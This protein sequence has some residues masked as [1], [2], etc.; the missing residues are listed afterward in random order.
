MQNKGLRF[1]WLAL[2]AWR[3]SR[4]NRSRLFLFI[5]SIIIG[6]AALVAIYSLSDNLKKEID[7]QA[8][9]LLGADLEISSR[10]SYS[11]ALLKIIDSLG[12]QRSEERRFSSMIFFTK[13]NGTRIIEVRALGGGFPYYG[14]LS[15]VPAAAGRSFRKG[16]Q[17]LVDQTLMLQFGAQVGDSV[18]IGNTV[19]AIAG[20]L[21][22]A[23][24]QTGVSASVAPVVYIPLETLAQTGLEQK[25]SRINYRYYVKWNKPVDMQAV[26][27]RIEEPFELEGINWDTV[28]SQKEDTARSF[29]DVTRF[30]SLVAFIALLLGCI[31]VASAIQIYIREKISTIAILRCLGTTARQAFLIYLIQIIAIGFI[32]SLIGAVLGTVVQQ[33]LPVVLKDL[34]PVEV[35]TG[36]S[37][38]SVIQG[39]VLGVMISILFALLSLVSIRKISPLNTLRLSFQHH[40]LVKDPVKWLVYVLLAFFI[41]G[42]TYLQLEGWRQALVFT[43]GLL[44]AFFVLSAIAALLMWAV[45]KFFPF[46]WSFL[47]RQGVANLYR[48]NNQTRILIVSIGLGTALIC[49]LFFIQTILLNRVVLTASGEQPNMVLFDIQSAQR[50]PLLT[51]ARKNGLPAEGTVP[52]VT[53]RLEAVNQVTPAVLRKDS[54]LRM[55]RWVF[56]REYRV[57]FRD[58]LIASEKLTRGKWTG[59]A[60]ESGP[61]YVSVEEGFAE[62]NGIDIGDTLHFNVQGV[63]MPTIVGSYR[64]VDWNRMQTNFLVVFPKG[65]L[66]EAPQFHV[67]LTRVPSTE[68]SARFQQAVVRQFPNIS[69]I[70]LGLVLNILNAIMDKVGFVIRF[71]AAFSIITGL[72]VLIASVLISKYQRMQ[73]NVLLRTLG[74]KSR[75]VFV[76]TALEYFILGA[77]AAATGIL[78]ALGGSWALA[79]FLFETTFT[80]QVLPVVIVFFAV[81][82][83]TV[84]IGLFNSRSALSR[85]PLEVLRQ[86]V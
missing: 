58:S 62:R 82:L 26:E 73:E 66:E 14:E 65:V 7:L 59:T 28:A 4:K 85:P 74:A 13:T 15:T 22:G 31:G 86:E 70:D 79:K 30:L 25:G 29:G 32:G 20:T 83:V 17:A 39:I 71:M 50:E 23:P 77:L 42:F 78:L 81:C 52:I 61:V 9:E 2:M 44:F 54:T 57:T 69:I 75:Q 16:R 27:A 34:L 55:Q 1:G 51:L 33:F 19:F 49:T 37:W 35:A 6:I 76:I 46:S 84:A 56:S 68:V 38:P 63:V 11:P 41:F 24:G 47:F 3:D 72:I 5:S 45:R 10:R 48:P 8:A 21:N 53:M 64:S 12:D 67:L 40:S 43:G 80:P 36:I 60:G 18:R